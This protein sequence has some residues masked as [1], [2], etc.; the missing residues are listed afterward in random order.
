MHQRERESNKGQREVVRQ[1][2]VG[3]DDS[4][5]VVRWAVTPHCWVSVLSQWAGYSCI[6]QAGITLITE[7]TRRKG[8]GRVSVRVF[9][10]L[11]VWYFLGLLYPKKGR[12]WDRERTPP[13]SPPPP[14]LIR[15]PANALLLQ[16]RGG[17]PHHSPILLSFPLVLLIK[18]RRVL[19]ITT[20]V[21]AGIGSAPPTSSH[22]LSL[23]LF[24]SSLCV[25]KA[26]ASSIFAGG[27]G[28]AN[29]NWSNEVESFLIQTPFLH[30]SI[31]VKFI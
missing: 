17:F 1:R 28:G 24:L 19:K 29:S 10:L 15:C 13:P 18:T 25:S 7:I 2:G 12:Q 16:C 5:L 30:P 3:V 23:S 9:S 21:V 4:W 27:V 8:G 6:S 22:L 20:F 31:V 11:W 26:W 14:R